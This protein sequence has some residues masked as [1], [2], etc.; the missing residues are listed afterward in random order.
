MSVWA[1]LAAAGKGLRLDPS[2]ATPKQFMEFQGV[3]LFWHSAL[4]FARVAGI[5]GIVFV[6]P[7]DGSPDEYTRLLDELDAGRTLGLE[8]RIAL[9]G[10]TRQESVRNGL[11]VLPPNCRR[12]LV[13]D[14]ARPFADTSLIVRVL[15][16]LAAGHEAVIPGLPLTDT[17]KSLD[18]AGLVAATP[19]RARLRAVQTP[20][21]FDRAVLLRAHEAAAH[22]AATDDA[23]LVEAL[24]LPVLVV[25]GAEGN[26]KIT[27]PGDLAILEAG[28]KEMDM[29]LCCGFGYDVHR[30]GGDR[31]FILG[32]VPI[33]TDIRIQAHSDG[34]TLFHALMDA[35]LGCIGGGDIGGMFPDSDP[36]YAGIS[37]GLL[38]AEVRERCLRAGLELHHADITITAQAPRIAP[39]RELIAKNVATL[40]HLPPQSVN[41]KATTEEGLGFTGEKKGIKVMAQVVGKIPAQGR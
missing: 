27:T 26:R 32:G 17:V 35:L 34:D 31:P 19:E 5:S 22:T 39:H 1:L 20:Q 25:D 33:P 38:L 3:P 8:R 14:A 15:D 21:G 24:G 2:G 11:A 12:V 13:H 30:Y 18:D 37:S 36:N 7:P 41:V 23:A 28:H 10:S 29:R 40:L 16:A 6:F 4:A 9:G